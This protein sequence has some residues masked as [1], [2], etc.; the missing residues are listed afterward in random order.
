MARADK[1]A[2]Q[3]GAIE[4][5]REMPDAAAAPPVPIGGCQGVEIWQNVLP[6]RS[7]IRSRIGSTEEAV[8]AS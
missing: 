2:K 5:A 4:I 1:A 6:E 7:D 8:K 3:A